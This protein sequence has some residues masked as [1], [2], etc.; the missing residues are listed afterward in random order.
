MFIWYKPAIQVLLAKQTA[1]YFQE[2]F[3]PLI[4]ICLLPAFQFNCAIINFTLIIS[5]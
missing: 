4:Q 5:Q 2:V 3:Y 1:G